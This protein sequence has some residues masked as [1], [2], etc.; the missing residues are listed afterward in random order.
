MSNAQK[1]FNSAHPQDKKRFDHWSS[2]HTQLVWVYDKELEAPTRYP[3]TWEYTSYP[4]PVWFIR[5]G[6]IKLHLKT[7]TE[8]Y[9]AGTWVF[10]PQA[11]GRQEIA[12]NTHLV[13]I[14]FISDWPSGA[15]LFARP[16][17]ISFADDEAP[18]LSSAT[19]QLI[20]AVN[21][22]KTSPLPL[23][24]EGTFTQYLRL[25]PVFHAWLYAYY[26]TLSARGI[27]PVT[28]SQ[29]HEKT[30]IALLILQSHPLHEPFQEQNLATKVG[31]SISQLNKLFRKDL[32]F[33]PLTYWNKR[34]LLVAYSELSQKNQSIKSISYTLGFSSPSNFTRWFQRLA[35]TSPKEYR[36]NNEE[37][38]SF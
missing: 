4:I 29:L 13:S 7:G 8:T 3:S 32:G 22:E 20:A 31:I 36:D 10:P 5:K 27:P 12:T 11:S 37:N 21:Q 23:D 2:L 24:L 35:G 6:W 15:H 26:E 25:Q 9:T 28:L 34:R 16:H 17:T 1:T 14:R 33:T 19:R 18:V 30:R 38:Q